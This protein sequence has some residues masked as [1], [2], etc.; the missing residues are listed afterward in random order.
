VALAALT[1]GAIL[2]TALLIGPAASALR[3]T[4]RP[5]RAMVIAA[6]IGITAT[7]LGVVL[8]YDS[9]YW[10]PKGHG[11]PVS[12]F[13]VTLVL[14]AYLLARLAALIRARRKAR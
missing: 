9:F 7:W 2:G 10:P 12:F 1:I 14:A 4:N 6:A 3:L 8:A 13:V 5:G 11:W